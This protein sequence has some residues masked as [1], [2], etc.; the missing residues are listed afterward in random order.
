M[1][2]CNKQYLLFQDLGKHEVVAEFD[3][4]T[5]SSD[6]GAFLLSEID[7]AHGLFDSFS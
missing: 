4:G 5:I 6:A 3:R 1:T 7:L 2:Q